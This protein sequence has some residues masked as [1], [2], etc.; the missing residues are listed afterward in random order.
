MLHV[1]RGEDFIPVTDSV[2]ISEILTLF[3]WSGLNATDPRLDI[4]N[5]TF[6]EAE[7]VVEAERDNV[8]EVLSIPFVVVCLTLAIRS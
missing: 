8:H 2:T 7:Q 5:R 4:W 3:P 6:M 1:W